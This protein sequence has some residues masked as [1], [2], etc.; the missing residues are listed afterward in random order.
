MQKRPE[1]VRALFE[2][3]FQFDSRLI[4]VEKMLNYPDLTN[5]G[6]KRA[7]TKGRKLKMGQ[8]A[9]LQESSKIL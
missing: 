1:K 3:N 2:E 9:F 4:K 5:N 6:N 7:A 8:M